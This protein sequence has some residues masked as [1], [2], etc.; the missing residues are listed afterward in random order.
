MYNNRIFVNTKKGESR[1]KNESEIIMDNKGVYCT[2]SQCI[3]NEK[4]CKCNLEKIEVSNE[5]TGENCV[6]V[7]H[8]CKSYKERGV[9]STCKEGCS[10]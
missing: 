4:S 6:A 1:I 10:W 9:N 2:V 5:K 7:P 8:F 3:Y